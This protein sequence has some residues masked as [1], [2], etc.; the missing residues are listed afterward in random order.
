MAKSR[1]RKPAPKVTKKQ[2]SRRRRE[3]QQT[4]WIWITVAA[5]AAI[6]VIV[7]GVGLIAQNAR[8]LA[9]VNGESIKALEYEARVRFYY[10]SL[11]PQVFETSEGEDP[12]EIYRQI[13]DLLI[14]EVLIRQEASKRGIA[15]TEDEVQV[16]IEERWF[17]H[18]RDPLP[19]PT[20][21]PEATPTPIGTP[22]APT[23]TPDTPEIFAANYR[24]FVD[25]VLQAARLSEAKFR[26]IAEASVLRDK[27][28]EAVI[29]ELPS[30]EE[31]VLFRYTVASDPEQATQKIQEIRAGV[32]E[33]V[34]ARHILVETLEAAQTVLQRLR[35]GEDFAALAAELSI[36]TSNKDDGGDLGWFGRGAMVPEFEQ[37]A[38]DG[39]IGIYP[40]PVQTQFGFHVI[41][42]LGQ[43][44]RPIDL[45]Q[46]LFEA[47][48]FGKSRL[49]GQF[50]PVFAEML[51]EAEIG[52]LPDAVPTDFGAAIVEVLDREV[53]PLEESEKLSRRQE[54][55]DQWLDEVQEES[56]ID[57]RWDPSLIPTR[58]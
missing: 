52:L 49:A 19:T 24:L 48:W 9:L 57:D 6:V 43:E 7:V 53:R 32:R 27:L 2:M 41:E 42:K 20:I 56:N 16:R 50:G 38:F 22:P 1:Q 55:F 47:G 34:H 46:E 8:I 37:A 5:V 4:R 35:D 10:Y 51:F 11:G 12:N 25:N 3:Q 30:E 54:L 36:D 58:M 18:Y 45:D 44:E 39:E 33:E 28:E 40:E 26:Q 23:A 31:Q 13:A 29:A 14:E 17:Q 21:D 15:A